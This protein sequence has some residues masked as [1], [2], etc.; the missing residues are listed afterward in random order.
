MF[1]AHFLRH[2]LRYIEHQALEAVFRTAIYAIG[3]MDL[4]NEVFPTPDRREQSLMSDTMMRDVD[5]ISLE[6]V[7]GIIFAPSSFHPFFLIF[8]SVPRT[9]PDSR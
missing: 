5:V 4:M 6:D 3:Y 2:H 1:R 9:N 8:P 7:C